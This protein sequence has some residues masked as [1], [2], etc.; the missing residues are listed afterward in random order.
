[1][2]HGPSG[3]LETTQTAQNPEDRGCDGDDHDQDDWHVVGGQIV[4]QSLQ[5]LV[6]LLPPLLDPFLEGLDLVVKGVQPLTPPPFE[7]QA[8]A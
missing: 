7:N 4:V 1:M 5:I 8:P 6:R 2:C 3:V